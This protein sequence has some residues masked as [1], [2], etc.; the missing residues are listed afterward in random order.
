MGMVD[1]SFTAVFGRPFFALFYS[2][3][4][5]LTSIKMFLLKTLKFLFLNYPIFGKSL[6]F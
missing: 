6:L 1:K 5:F 4:I 2:Y 3:N